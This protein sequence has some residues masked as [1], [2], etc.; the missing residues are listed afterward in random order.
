MLQAGEKE[1]IE[2]EKALRRM[3]SMQLEKEQQ[4]M[5]TSQ[6]DE[7]GSVG[8]PM[9]G[10]AATIS[11]PYSNSPPGVQQMPIPQS[12]GVTSPIAPI[13]PSAPST[14][15]SSTELDMN[16]PPTL[17]QSTAALKRP[18]LQEQSSNNAT[19]AAVHEDRAAGAGVTAL[20]SARARVVCGVCG[21]TGS[22]STLREHWGSRQCLRC[23]RKLTAVAVADGTAAI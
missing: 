8:A 21:T 6:V 9:F 3:R 20:C 5:Q 13:P 1:R 4:A 18:L 17:E 14:E 19:Q 23:V 11:T 22:R 10:G 12:Y 2:R 16:D 7:F 15:D